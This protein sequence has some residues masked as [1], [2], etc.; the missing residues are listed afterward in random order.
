MIARQ[1]V[2]PV[3]TDPP[4][5]CEAV[6]PMPKPPGALSTA[7]RWEIIAENI[8][9]LLADGDRMAKGF[10]V[11]SFSLLPA[12][13]QRIYLRA[14][15]ESIVRFAAPDLLRDAR[16]AAILR[17]SERWDGD[18]GD[19]ASRATCGRMKQAWAHG[20]VQYHAALDGTLSIPQVVSR[21]SELR[22]I[23]APRVQ[24]GGVM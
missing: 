4:G 7:H 16:D 3:I 1:S 6:P 15:V 17:A 8:A 19:V 13:D 9:A 20:F 5:L 12:L 24:T 11:Q 22:L 10:P 23:V 21:A 2:T 18:S 14:A